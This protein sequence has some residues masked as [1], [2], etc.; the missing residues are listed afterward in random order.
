MHL[1]NFFHNIGKPGDVLSLGMGPIFGQTLRGVMV[2]LCECLL[3]M[4][5]SYSY[6]QTTGRCVMNYNLFL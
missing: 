4:A 5:V 6:E 3:N 1:G 2:L